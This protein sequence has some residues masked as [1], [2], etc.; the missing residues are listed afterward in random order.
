MRAFG[1]FLTFVFASAGCTSQDNGVKT[2][3][4]ANLSSKLQEENVVLIDVRTTAEVASGYIP[5]TRFFLDVNH[6]EF[7][8]Q[9]SELDTSKIYIMYCRSGARSSR[10]ANQLMT[11]GV[12]NVY[13]LDGGILSYRGKLRQ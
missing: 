13:N 5:E 12:K 11:K 4:Q 6:A 3:N 8:Q 7:D 9:I 1:I 10:A 2:L